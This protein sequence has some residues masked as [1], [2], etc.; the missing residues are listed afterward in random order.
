MSDRSE[1]EVKNFFGFIDALGE[2]ETLLLRAS[3]R[4]T[5]DSEGTN[6]IVIRDYPIKEFDRSLIELET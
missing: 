6:T 5:S 4:K 2:G 1:S 3:H